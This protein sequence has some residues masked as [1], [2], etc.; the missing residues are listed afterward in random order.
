[1]L[2]GSLPPELP[3]NDDRL[4]ALRQWLEAELGLSVRH[5]QPASSDASFRR[6]FRV[7]HADGVHVAMDA[8]PETEDC[9]P[10]I[11][12]A[13][14]LR[15]A[16]IHVPHIEAAAPDRGFLLLEDL[17]RHT[18][19]DVLAE[20][21]ADAMFDLAVDALI[22]FQAASREGVLP[23]YD[24]ALLR[25]E[26]ELFPEWYL[27]H[28]LRVRLRDAERQWLSAQFDRLVHRAVEQSR[29]WVHRD[30]MPRNLMVS[31]PMPGVLDFQDAV[32]GPVSYD[33]TCL[34]RDAFLS[35]PPERVEHW[36]RVYWE[37]A[38]AAGIPVPTDVDC[39]LR[40]CVWMG[41]QRHLKVMGIF[42]RIRYRDGKP[43]YLQDTPRFLG[44]LNEAADF[45]PQLRELVERVH[46]WHAAA[47][48]T[49]T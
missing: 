38:R 17:G 12:V 19:L 9:G 42:A 3:E 5:L 22:R 15:D 27:G 28:H 4:H 29:V 47:G 18:Y 26:L 46:A 45:D 48:E 2:N 6:Y 40:D 21:N 8:P 35:W 43:R 7:T 11:H 37:R 49:T 34:F 44:Y 36:L 16:G 23:A 20:S 32:Y 14:L 10:F 1:M 24:A 31:N 25:R 13:R 39:F 33:I 30:Y 41:V